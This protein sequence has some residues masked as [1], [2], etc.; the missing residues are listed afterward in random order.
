MIKCI[1]DYF[2]HNSALT[3]ARSNIFSVLLHKPIDCCLS[4]APVTIVNC[5]A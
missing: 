5:Y 4:E 1:S 2:L 3:T